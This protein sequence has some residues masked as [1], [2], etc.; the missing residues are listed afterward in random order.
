MPIWT[1]WRLPPAEAMAR[2]IRRTFGPNHNDSIHDALVEL[3]KQGVDT[4]KVEA[5]SKPAFYA[6]VLDLKDDEPRVLVQKFPKSVANWLFDQWNDEQ[7]AGRGVLN[8]V[9]WHRFVGAVRS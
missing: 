7:L 2:D 6:N 4:S 8:P 9:R 3:R 5:K 1:Y